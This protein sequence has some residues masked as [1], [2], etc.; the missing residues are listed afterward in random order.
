MRN[1]LLAALATLSLSTVALA[2]QPTPAAPTANQ[3][4]DIAPIRVACRDEVKAKNLEG[5]ARRE[6][7]RAC[8][9]AKLPEGYAADGRQKAKE[10][11][12]ACRKEVD[13]TGVTGPDRRAAVQKCFADKRPDLAKAMAF[14]K[15]ANA[16]GLEG[17]AFRQAVQACR[18]AA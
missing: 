12:E 14:R 1:V 18:N 11:R 6:A 16:K 7:M 13:A 4:I 3:Q 15:D 2:Q 17:D 9:K 10:V 8:L 5:D